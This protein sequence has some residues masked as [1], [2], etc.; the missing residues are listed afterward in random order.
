MCYK[1]VR[2]TT[3]LRQSTTFEI[4]ERPGE[5]SER[6]AAL[7]RG[8][9]LRAR[10]RR[11]LHTPR[12]S[13]E[14]DVPLTVVYSVSRALGAVHEEVEDVQEHLVVPHQGLPHLSHKVSSQIG[15]RRVSHWWR[16]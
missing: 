12:G 2:V 8:K 10:P 3:P 14:V 15:A 11:T 16:H 4:H 5:G 7:G 1:K 13:Y 6:T 9:C